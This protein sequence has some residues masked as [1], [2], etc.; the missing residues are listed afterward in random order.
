MDATPGI[1]ITQVIVDSF[2]EYEGLHA[3]VLFSQGCNLNC[4]YCYNKEIA[5]RGSR[6][7]GRSRSLLKKHLTPLHQAVVFLGGEPTVWG[8]HLIEEI[9]YVHEELKL[10]TKIFTNGLI[11]SIV[12][13]ALSMNILDAISID[14]KA[15]S[16]LL[17]II[18]HPIE[19]EDY[20][21]LIGVT[22]NAALSAGVH[23]E[24]RT[25]KGAGV[26]FDEI[27][28]YVSSHFPGVKHIMQEEMVVHPTM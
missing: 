5:N 27:E 12:R 23:V 18:G 2:Q 21:G 19:V 8:P 9:R 25:T 14:L 28:K 13:T 6:T 7:L 3:L 26:N 4:S 11:P 20:L 16:N 15:I 22:V 1:P 10:K 17:P 24:I